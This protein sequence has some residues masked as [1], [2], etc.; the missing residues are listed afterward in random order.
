[1]V[2][3]PAVSNYMRKIGAKGGRAGK[4]TALRSQ[5][6]RKAALAMW[7]KKRS[8][9]RCDYR[10]EWSRSSLSVSPVPP[11]EL[12]E[13]LRFFERR[14]EQGRFVAEWQNLYEVSE[15]TL[16]T[17]PGFLSRI[18][19]Y[20][21]ETGATV[22]V[23]GA[24]GSVVTTKK[25]QPLPLAVQHRKLVH[26]LLE[27]APGAAAVANPEDFGDIVVSLVNAIPDGQAVVVVKKLEEANHL[28][29]TIRC[30]VNGNRTVGILTGSAA[31]SG[32]VVVMTAHHL[33]NRII[34][35]ESISLLIFVDP[36]RKGVC[37]LTELL[38]FINATKFALLRPQEYPSWQKKLLEAAFGPI[39]VSNKCIAKIAA[40]R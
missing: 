20:L 35:P 19:R 32:T 21:G 30:Q 6:N 24:D 2:I 16:T 37:W 1:M 40:S 10:V 38:A 34:A 7:A 12:L 29:Q 22:K 4:G 26:R 9:E 17:T 15:A 33:S 25:A 28:Y 8:G 11:K 39:V 23:T 18:V 31:D 13:Q 27:N 14:L 3:H 36:P 5:L